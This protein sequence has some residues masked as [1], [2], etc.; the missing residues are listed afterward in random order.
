MKENESLQKITSLKNE[1]AL[2]FSWL[3]WE[4]KMLLSFLNEIV[5]RSCNFLHKSEIMNANVARM[6]I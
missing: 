4:E 1:V 5:M 3:K 6:P 2:V